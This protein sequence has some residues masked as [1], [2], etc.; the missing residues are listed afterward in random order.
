MHI[1]IL[2]K[3]GLAQACDYLR[4]DGHILSDIARLDGFESAS[5]MWGWFEKAYG[6]DMFQ[7]KFIVVRWK[8]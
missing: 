1:N 5:D 2:K 8:P 4:H 3:S 7:S 6:K